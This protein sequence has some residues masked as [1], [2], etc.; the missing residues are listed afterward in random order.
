MKYRLDV[1]P[2]QANESIEMAYPPQPFLLRAADLNYRSAAAA[3]AAA[4]ASAAAN[5][6]QSAY[7]S[8][9][10]GPMASAGFFGKMP[11]NLGLTSGT[12][13][14]G[15]TLPSATTGAN[16]FI[17]AEDV[18]A[19][20]QMAAAA[21]AAAAAASGNSTSSGGGSVSTQPGGRPPFEPE[22]DGIE[23]DPKVTLE[24]KDLWEKF[25]SLGTEMVITKSGR[26][27]FPSFRIRVSGLDKKAKYIMLMDIVAADDCRYKF[28]NSR[29]VMAG[30]ADPEMPKRMYIHPDSPSTG[31]QWMQ[32]VVSFHKL[33]LT[34]NIADKHGFTI[35]NS[36]HKYQP[37]FHLVRANDLLK[38]PY[39]TFRTYVFK[40]TEFIA[41][42]AYQNEKITRL[43]IDNN[44]FA[45]GFRETGAGKREKKNS[46][47]GMGNNSSGTS[48]PPSH[49]H[50]GHH[51]HAHHH[52]ASYLLNGHDKEFRGLNAFEKYKNNNNANSSPYGKHDQHSDDE[53]ERVD[54]MDDDDDDARTSSSANGGHIGNSQS[55]SMVDVND[56]HQKL[57]GFDPHKPTSAI[58]TKGKSENVKD[59]FATAPNAMSSLSKFG[60][61]ESRTSNGFPGFPLPSPSSDLNQLAS[62]YAGGNFGNGLLSAA[63]G[64]PSLFSRFYPPNSFMGNGTPAAAAA[65]SMNNAAT[66]AP[67]SND[68]P[69]ARLAAGLGTMPSWPSQP[70]LPP[71][72][73]RLSPNISQNSTNNN[74][75]SNSNSS[76][77]R[78]TPPTTS[79]GNVSNP[80][81]GPFGGGSGPN[82][83]FPFFPPFGLHPF[84]LPGATAGAENFDMK[85]FDPRA[86]LSAY[87]GAF[88]NSAPLGDSGNIPNGG[89]LH[90]FGNS[91]GQ[92][93]L[94]P[95]TT[96]SNI[97][98]GSLGSSTS[99]ATMA[100]SSQQTT[101]SSIISGGGGG[102]GSSNSSVSSSSKHNSPVMSTH[103]STKYSP[104]SLSSLNEQLEQGRDLLQL[105]ETLNQR[106]KA[107]SN[108]SSF[109]NN[110]AFGNRFFPYGIRPFLY[111]GQQPQSQQHYGSSGKHGNGSND[112][113][114]SLI[115]PK[116]DTGDDGLR[117]V[118]KLRC[119][120]GAS[121]E[122]TSPAQSHSSGHESRCS[123][124]QSGISQPTSPITFGTSEKVADKNGSSSKESIQELKNMQRMVE[125]LDNGRSNAASAATIAAT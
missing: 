81:L 62:L 8:A 16:S 83:S 76:S 54:I 24:A 77:T 114:K 40:E 87:F 14:Q 89:M 52:A 118:K 63:Y 22:D 46:L 120:S 28:H 10:F 119:S 103:E 110:T 44:P 109:S 99:T 57:F 78:T 6:P 9:L 29:W 49:H 26:R 27:M 72:P 122:C 2:Y 66:N 59:S 17:T 23:D 94:A 84:G 13:S 123:S 85:N 74:N 90:P 86:M 69:M 60:D 50:H 7:L 65:T 3:A 104:L 35:L 45:K 48:L 117:D 38:L 112:T 25:H 31:E 93:S 102:G 113:D 121:S 4:A 11:P 39:S 37:R 88:G 71:P 12:G 61:V 116:S 36:M 56:F 101:T 41:V 30:K 92:S 64:F 32:K 107:T 100:Q 33:K 106:F 70:F 97:T 34:N 80:M 82:P 91:G 21:A 95:T 68:E 53:D 111:N 19:S 1:E 47:I 67:N 75:N 15:S 58:D 108:V 51:H 124:P 73:Q 125:G 18:L 5:Q 105:H 43:K 79:S 55:G 42:T 98:A 115:S 20:H 96:H